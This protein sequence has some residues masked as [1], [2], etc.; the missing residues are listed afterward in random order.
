MA[1]GNYEPDMGG[2]E[3]QAPMGEQVLPLEE[4]AGQGIDLAQVLPDDQL[5]RIAAKCLEAFERDKSERSEWDGDYDKIVEM[6][7]GAR[8]QKSFPWIGASNVKYP[9]IATAAVQFNARAYPAIVKG[10]DVVKT[11]VT[12]DD[13]DGQKRAR[14]DRIQEHMNWQ[15]L[16]DNPEWEEET[17]KLCMMLPIHGC[18]FRQVIWD[19]TYSRHKTSLVSAKD[20]VVAQNAKDLET[21]PVFTKVFQSFEHE[22]TEKMRDGRYLEVDIKFDDED[23]QG[24]QE[25]LECHCRYDLDEDG[26]SEPYIAVI[27]KESGKL[28]SLTAGFWPDGVK[29]GEPS[30]D[31]PNGRVLSVRRHVEFIKYDFMPDFEGK[32]LG[33]G[34]GFLLR[35]HNE[36]ISTI[37]NQLLDAA[38][39]Q[40]TGGGFVGRGVGL[41][42]GSLVFEPGEWKMVNVAGGDLRSNIVP[43]PT[44]QP[45]PALFQLLGLMIDAGKE[46]ASVRDVLTGEAGSA[47]QPAT[48]TL[49]I[50]EQGLQVFSAI[51]K[52]VYRSLGKELKL[53]RQLNA[54]YLPDEAYFTVMDNQQ[55][56][57]RQDYAMND[58]DVAPV[59]DPSVTTSAQRL[60]KAEYLNTFRGDPS[61]DQAEITRRQ[62]MA[63]QIDDIES[64]MPKPDPQQ[65]AMQQQEM[66]QAKALQQRG[67][68]AE[69]AKMEGEALKL[70]ADAMQAMQP[71][72]PAGPKGLEPRDIVAAEKL[73]LDGRKH[74]DAMALKEAEMLIKVD[75]AEKDRAAHAAE[76]QF[77]ARISQADTAIERAMNREDQAMASRVVPNDR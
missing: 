59:A 8:N 69:V 34:F 67:A 51:Y 72:T 3:V 31:Y 71:E 1:D 50:I 54:A 45:S 43:R 68:E 13:P 21:V 56:I 62:L 23:G 28:L 12:G 7:R 41:Q 40:N 18:V 36:V 53:M 61:V 2:D 55:A 73:K 44:S 27:H 20:L 25:M 75:Q 14:A 5:Q 74:Q 4:I 9:L 15:L 48:T 17:D 22:I 29:R 66:M 49:A 52:R 39:D 6:V 63:A 46:L 16:V 60:A 35:D 65:Q 26:Y 33:L 11:S 42:G 19:K 30:E 58:H 32:F 47:N 70:R 57:A 10:K 37:I 38:T 24:E 77:K 64:L 76:V